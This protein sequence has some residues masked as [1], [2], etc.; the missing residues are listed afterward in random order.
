MGQGGTEARCS[1]TRNG[2]HSVTRPTREV[3][4]PGR[5]GSGLGVSRVCVCVNMCVC[6]CVNA[7]AR[8]CV[9][10]SVCACVSRE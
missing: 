9:C 8:V 5:V 3:E 2:C 7:R 1:V 10:V 4:K 6:V